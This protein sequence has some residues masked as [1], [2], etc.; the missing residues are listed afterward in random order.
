[1][2]I[3][4]VYLSEEEDEDEDGEVKI[5]KAMKILTAYLSISEEGDLSEDPVYPTV[6]T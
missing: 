1:M 5:L 4:T 6:S 3:R 2:T